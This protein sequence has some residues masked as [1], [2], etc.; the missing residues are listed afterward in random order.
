MRFKL[1]KPNARFHYLFE[2]RWNGIYMMPKHVFEK[3]DDLA[4]YTNNPPS[5]WALICRSQFDPN[6]FW[7]L[8]ERRDDW[9]RT[10][11]GIVTGN[12]GPEYVLT[13]FYGDSAK[14]AIAMSRGELDVF[15]DADFEA[16]QKMLESEPTARSWYKN[17]PWAYPNEIST[18]EFVFN[19][20]N[21]P[22]YQNK[23]V[24]WAL[25]L[26]INIVDLQTTYIGGVAK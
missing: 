17:F 1:K 14:K 24:R 25:A 19:M 21:D 20:E 15:F 6:G 3:I 4:T 26:A 13:I 12:A 2:A 22:I 5:C 23:D 9:Q 8:Y 18:R 7:E 16:F 11:A 10:P